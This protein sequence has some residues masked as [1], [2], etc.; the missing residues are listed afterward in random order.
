[1]RPVYSTGVKKKPNSVVNNNNIENGNQ[2]YF[3]LIS[4][5]TAYEAWRILL[6]KKKIAR[7]DWCPRNVC[8]FRLR[9]SPANDIF[10]S[11]RVELKLKANKKVAIRD[12]NL[13]SIHVVFT[14]IFLPVDRTACP[15]DARKYSLMGNWPD[16]YATTAHNDKNKNKIT[17]KMNIGTLHTTNWHLKMFVRKN[18]NKPKKKKLI[19]KHV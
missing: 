13:N 3:S 1:M 18:T 16:F 10:V 14:N 15:E 4:S 2:C 8:P 9:H 19:E 11:K 17:P 6:W 7:F 12:L 5:V